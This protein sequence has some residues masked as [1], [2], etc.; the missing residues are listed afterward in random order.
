MKSLRRR[1]TLESL[2]SREVPALLCI[3]V[4]ALSEAANLTNQPVDS[5]GNPLPPEPPPAGTG[6]NAA[7]GPGTPSPAGSAGTTPT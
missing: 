6:T 7:A 4:S 1:L 2:D 3:A 5:T